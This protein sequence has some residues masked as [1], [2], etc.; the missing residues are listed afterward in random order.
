MTNM[1][2]SIEIVADS[3]DVPEDTWQ[4]L[5]WRMMTGRGQ[6]TESELENLKMM[7]TAWEV[8]QGWLPGDI[9]YDHRLLDVQV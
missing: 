8:T 2:G 4:G 3:A 1:L 9:G 6:A 7:L 5:I